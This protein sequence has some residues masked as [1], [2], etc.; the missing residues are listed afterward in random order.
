VSVLP[1]PVALDDPPGQPDAV[2]AV[3][4]DARSAAALLQELADQVGRAHAPG[5]RS[6]DGRT[7]ADRGA[8]ISRL[9]AD[10]AESLLRAAAR[11]VEHAEIWQAVRAGLAGLRS[12]QEQ[13]EPAAR[14]R[15]ALLVDPLDPFGPS[16]DDVLS[17]W[18][19]AE[20]RRAAE[21]HRLLG[22]L[23]DDAAD[24]SRVLRACCAVVG[25]VGGRGRIGRELV[26]L[27][28][29]LPGWAAS[30]FTARGHRLAGVLARGPTAGAEEAATE[31]LG[32]A[33]DPVFAS[34]FLG[35]LGVEG[36]R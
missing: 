8:S 14:R 18:V 9:T 22:L 11:L 5:W 34:A 7:A 12:E 4:A 32:L 10:S 30:E 16:A 35:A 21:R 27:A 31:A 13:E 36:V 6:E 26:H 25:S 15:V 23:E 33:G 28:A 20:Q 17:A 29:L 2:L 24:T 19:A 1:D 3:A